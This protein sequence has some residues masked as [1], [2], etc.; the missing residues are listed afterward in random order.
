QRDYSLAFKLQLVDQV[1]KGKV[2]Y[3]HAQYQYGIQGCSTIFGSGFKKRT[4]TILLIHHSNRGI[5]YC[6]SEYQEI[7]K[8]LNIQCSMT[9]GYDCYQNAL[10]ERINGILKMEYLLIK[11]SN[12]EQARKLVEESIQ[13]YNEKRPHLSLNYK[14]PDEVHR[15]FYA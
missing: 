6:S 5:L 2:T 1:E 13:L 10:A 3:K 9:D 12:L 7:H 14:T 8:E 15:A 4:S 11:P